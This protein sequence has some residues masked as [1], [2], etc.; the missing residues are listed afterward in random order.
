V[1]KTLYAIKNTEKTNIKL[2]INEKPVPSSITFM[3]FHVLDLVAVPRF[4]IS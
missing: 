3:N 2:I 4:E 1:T